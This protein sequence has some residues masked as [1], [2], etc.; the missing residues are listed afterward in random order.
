MA[1]PDEAQA[2]KVCTQ[3]FTAEAIAAVTDYV[4]EALSGVL[5]CYICIATLVN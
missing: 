3:K 2:N 1:E 4:H 5:M